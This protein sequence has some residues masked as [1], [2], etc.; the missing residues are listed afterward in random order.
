MPRCDAGVRRGRPLRA[1]AAGAPVAAHATRRRVSVAADLDRELPPPRR[2]LARCSSA[3]TRRCWPPHAAG[4]RPAP[5]HGEVLPHYEAAS[6]ARRAASRA[7]TT[8]TTATRSSRSARRRRGRRRAGARLRRRRGAARRAR[9]A[10][11][12]VAPPGPAGRRRPAGELRLRRVPLDE[13]M[14]AACRAVVDGLEVEF[15]HVLEHL[16]AG[17][18]AW[19]RARLARGASSARVRDALVQG[20]AGPRAYARGPVVIED[21]RTTR[22]WRARPLREHGVVSSAKVLL[23]APTTPPGVLGATPGPA[24]SASR[25]ST[26][27]PP[28]R[29]S[30]TARSRACARRSGSATTRCTTRSPGCRTARCCSTASARR[31]RADAEGRRLALFFLDVDH[32]K[33]LNDSLGHHAGDE[34]L[35]AIGPRLRAVLRPDDT[36]ARFGGD[37]FAVLCEGV[38]DEAHALR[39]A[40]RLVRAFAQPFEVRGEPR[41][42]ST[43]VGVVVSE[44]GG[45]ARPRRAA[46]T[47]TRRSTAPRSAAAAATRSST[48]A[49]A[50]ARPRGCRS[51]PT[52]AA[53]SRPAT[54]CGSPTSPTTRCPARDRRR[55]GAAALGPPRARPDPA[56]RVHPRRRGLRPDRR[57]GRARAAHRLP[58]R[59]RLAGGRRRWRSASTSPRAR[60]S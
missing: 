25:T 36:I 50:T 60:W 37:E 55:G 39:V 24:R 21:P 13:L 27:S 54:S 26:S 45:P 20:R 8:R 43:S 35:R 18:C 31:S 51:R 33:V 7:A 40:E 44:P 23:G 38:G 6:P 56:R 22:R 11:R 53:R 41:F 15:V 9:G 17:R 49:C 29:T 32:L 59:R 28:S 34:L 2:R 52:C 58:R 42:C 19:R 46:R 47:P 5:L 12:A 3:T 16:G 1:R 48:P 57:P 4:H 30:S 14:E 10:P